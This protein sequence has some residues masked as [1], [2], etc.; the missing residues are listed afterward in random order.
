[1]IYETAEDFKLHV[2]HFLC[3][4]VADKGYRPQ[5]PSPVLNI[6]H[7]YR[8]GGRVRSL[9]LVRIITVRSDCDS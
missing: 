6:S 1:M 5:K 7:N 4:K 9:N 8:T 2:L 3:W